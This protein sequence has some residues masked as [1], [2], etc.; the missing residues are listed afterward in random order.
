MNTQ[1]DDFYSALQKTPALPEGIFPAVTTTIRRRTIMVRTI[2]SVVVVCLVALGTITLNY[3]PKTTTTARATT[4]TRNQTDATQVDEELQI[5][6][7]YLNGNNLEE[8]YGQYAV[9]DVTY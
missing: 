9:L 7:D 3:S 2:T 6:R 8:E 1:P 4:I 5:I